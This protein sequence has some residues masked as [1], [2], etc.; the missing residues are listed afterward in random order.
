MRMALSLECGMGVPGPLTN[1]LRTQPC[2]GSV[3]ELIILISW[4]ISRE[5][6]DLNFKGVSFEGL[7][8][9]LCLSESKFRNNEARGE[10]RGVCKQAFC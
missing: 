6:L 8:T 10:W 4:Y 7:E 1:M 2:P 9:L 3:E 5:L